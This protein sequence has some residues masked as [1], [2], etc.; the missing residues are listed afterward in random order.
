MARTE[1][2]ELELVDV[3]RRL[4]RMDISPVE[5]TEAV[6][7]RI[8]K[9]DGRLGSYALVTAD[10]A[11][12]QAQAAERELARGRSRGPLHGVPVAVKDL[13]CTKGIV[14]A[15]GT[16][17]FGQFKPRHDATVVARL[18]E[19]G[20]V[21][22]GKLQMTE[23]A[24]AEHHPEITP[25]VNPWGADLWTGVSS[26]GSGVA[27]A[28][29]LCFGSLGSDTGGSIRFPSAANGVTGLKPTWGRVSRF[30]VFDL[31]P[32]LDHV[33]PMAR[34]AADCAAILSAIAGPDD[35]DPT[36]AQIQVP[37]YLAGIDRSIKGLKIGLDVRYNSKGV[38]AVTAAAVQGAAK[39]L[40]DLGA[41]IVDID[42]PDVDRVAAD[43]VRH[44][45]VET[46]HTHAAT[47]PKQKA[48][49]G[50][51]LAALI[52]V[53]RDLS[54]IE[55]QDILQHRA[56]FTGQVQAVLQDCD[57]VLMPAVPDSGVTLEQRQTL[58]A[59][60]KTTAHM[61]RFTAPIDYAG[62][63]A[64]TMPCGITS[65]GAPIG[66]QLV[67]RH[68]EEDLV[69]RAGHAFQRATDWHKARPAL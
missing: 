64:L 9:H 23:G 51:V 16:K 46:A 21:L 63:P 1:L 55:Y 69:L 37:N 25:P 67:G 28:A 4:Q 10:L 34:S 45:A 2:A 26:S 33:G 13:C 57:L 6:L 66:F 56:T 5:L 30:G 53:G 38:G 17:V 50:P 65:K 39:T 41:E 18:A 54:G 43:W 11:M 40:R 52:D 31:A 60:P 14:T 47:Y 68:F 3:S 58:R 44:C 8:E 49:Y 15:A 24:F 12:K 62:N 22:L 7:A 32:S 19:A 61:L 20:A 27:T 36:A 42:F 35:N 59:D 29:G 48:A